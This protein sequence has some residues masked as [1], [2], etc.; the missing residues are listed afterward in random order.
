MASQT[1]TLD[2]RPHPQLSARL[3]YR[4]DEAGAAVFSSRAGP[5]SAPRQDTLTLGVTS[6]F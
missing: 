3:E 1:L 2:V 4:H 6:W 5:L